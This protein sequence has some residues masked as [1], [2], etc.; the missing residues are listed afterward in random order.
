MDTRSSAQALRGYQTAPG[1]YDELQAPGG[2]V[3]AH[4]QMVLNR[5][6]H[7]GGAELMRLE[8]AALTRIRENGVTYNVYGED[9]ARQR[10]WD[11]DILPFVIS[12]ADWRQL[13]AGLVQRAQVLNAL[14]ADL[15]GEQKLLRSGALPAALV[16]AS[17]QFLRQAAGAP[18]PGKAFL[19]FYA[20]DLGRDASGAWRVLH[21]RSEAPTGAGYALENRIIV[22]QSLPELFRDAKVQRLAQFFARWRDKLFQLTGAQRPHAVLLTPGPLN[23]AYFEHAYLARYLGFSLVEGED[24]MVRDRQ[25]YLK[26]LAGPRKVD[27]ILRRTDSDLC[28]PL[29]L[30]SDSLVGVPGLMEAARA[31]QVVIANPAGAGAV[32]NRALMA[33]LPRLSRALIGEDLRLTSAETYW[34]GDPAMAADVRAGLDRL[35]V[36]EITRS[37][38]LLGGNGP[39]PK[40]LTPSQAEAALRHTGPRYF[41][42][43]TPVLSTAPM[44]ENGQLVARPLTLRCFVALTADG[45][46]AMPGGLARIADR[47][48]PLSPLRASA[49]TKDVWVLADGPVSNFSLLPPRGAKIELRRTGD[50]M[51]SRAAENLFWLGRY[52]ERAEDLARTLRALSTRLG[53]V[54]GFAGHASAADAA[55]RL[56]LP[57]GQVSLAAVETA[58]A[59]DLSALRAE[60]DALIAD[61]KNANGLRP[62]L[63]AVAGAAWRVRDR[64]SS[65]AWQA[66]AALQTEDG[67]AARDLNALIRTMAAFAGLANENMTRGP[68][69]LFLDLGRRVERSVNTAWLLESMLADGEA[70][71][72]ALPDILALTLDIADSF[73]TYR[74]RYLAEFEVAPVIDL[75][76]LDETNPRS[77]AFQIGEI[78]ARMA[79][80]PRATSAQLRGRDKEIIEFLAARLRSASASALAHADPK[81]GRPALRALLDLLQQRLP[82]LSDE[83][84]EAYF[85]HLTRRRAGAAPRLKA[86]G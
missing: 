61:P 57:M 50:D 8:A 36:T 13:E 81:G 38:S 10:P 21:D 55:R 25:V 18:V 68:A 72:A 44:E 42:E 30:R 62:M 63:R 7:A 76:L 12:A 24:L 51:P 56:L 70:A 41:A 43:S 20:A 83:L 6:T 65:D 48:A 58:G 78:K 16:A 85:R 19:H 82:G 84:T 39:E 46:V 1:I 15:Y 11:L 80:L 53:E 27:L 79:R 28:D 66:L 67:A 64:L 9:E 34:C 49:V 45:Y 4:W 32:E 71:D 52:T 26:T 35:A 23:P 37:R 74:G 77:A 73:M 33:F 5:L 29:E 75:L 2:A 54:S 22:S 47:A 86:G 59:G 17:P 14:L 40:I 60:L 69:F 31:G 3:R